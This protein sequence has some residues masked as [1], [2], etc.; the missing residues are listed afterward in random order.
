MLRRIIGRLHSQKFLFQFYNLFIFIV[1][2][3]VTLTFYYYSK[4]SIEDDNIKL[5]NDINLQLS[6]SVDIVMNDL[7]RLAQFHVMDRNIEEI[8]SKRNLQDSF[9]SIEDQKYIKN[10]IYLMKM[11]NAYIWEVYYMGLNGVIYSDDYIS[12]DYAVLLQNSTREIE[13]GQKR[14]ISDFYISHTG[15]NIPRKVI[16]V[17]QKTKTRSME[18]MGYIFYNLDE[19]KLS[20]IFKNSSA[21]N[22]NIQFMI[23]G[24]NDLIYE[25]NMQQIAPE[26]QQQLLEQIKL[27]WIPDQENVMKIKI[28]ESQY[29]VSAMEQT[30]TGWKL[31]RFVKSDT[32]LSMLLIKIKS[33]LLII[34]VLFI[35]VSLGGYYLYRNTYQSV[36]RLSKAMNKVKNGK[37][38]TLKEEAGVTDQVSELIRN[39]NKMSIQLEESIHKNYISEVNQKKLEL[40][41]LQSQINPHFLYNTLNLMSSIGTLNDIKEISEIADNLSEMFRYNIKGKQNVHIIEEIE[42]NRKYLEIQQMRFPNK[43]VVTYDCDEQLMNCSIPKFTLQP[44]VENAVYHGLE[45]IRR[46]GELLISVKQDNRDIIITVKDNG[47]GMDET[48]LLQL[49]AKLEE[50]VN[51]FLMNEHQSSLGVLNVHYRI[52]ESYGEAYGLRIISRENEG[53]TVILRIPIL[54]SLNE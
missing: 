50:D 5:M 35:V 40:K 21:E 31:I 32:L 18:D 36:D 27:R 51:R 34:L 39:F 24:Q 2:S 4:L 9:E 12:K 42:Q 25:S 49:I 8:L 10:V 15:N 11:N 44:I 37:F 16:T 26:E 17:T 7:D 52:K 38:I 22:R 48:T 33:F 47:K 14:I 43:F 19:K 3:T 46:K 54:R 30:K 53:T 41:I 23:L 6:Y 29:I 13:A 1:F 45:Q 20:S 28:G